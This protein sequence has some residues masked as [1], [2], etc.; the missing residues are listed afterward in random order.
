LIH[1]ACFRATSPLQV[2]EGSD[3]FPGETKE[4]WLCVIHILGPPCFFGLI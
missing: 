4:K 2:K 1:A 3:W